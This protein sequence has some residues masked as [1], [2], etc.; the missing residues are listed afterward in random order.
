MAQPEHDRVDRA[1]RANLPVPLTPFIGRVEERATLREA[2]EHNRLVTATGPGGVGKTRLALVVAGDLVGRYADGV[3]FV[4]LVQVTDPHGVAAATAEAV[5]VPE[6]IGVSRRESLLIALTHRE[7][8]LV[9]D[10]CEHLADAMREHIAELLAACPNVRVLATS[11]LR[12]LLPGERVMPVP[13]L[14]LGDDSGHRGDA[15]ELFMVRALASG[16]SDSMLTDESMVQDVCRS[17]AG[18]ALAI[19]LGASRV[20]SMGLD[21]LKRSLASG[22]DLQVFG[23][24]TDTRHRSLRATIE[25]SYHLLTPDEQKVLRACSVFAAP[26]SIDASAAVIGIEVA[27]ALESVGRLVD[28]SLVTL[29][30]GVTTRYRIL[31]AVRQFAHELSAA[32]GELDDL[33]Q[34]HGAWCRSELE[35]LLDTD[36][37]DSSWCDRVDAVVD[38]ARAALTWAAGDTHHHDIAVALAGPL[39]EVVFL[40]GRPSEAQQRYEQAA[41]LADTPAAARDLLLRAARAAL[42]RYV[43][44]EALRL[45]AQ[46]AAVAEA[47]GL[48]ELA[49]LDMA[50]S[51]TMY[52]RHVGTVTIRFSREHNEGLLERAAQL[53]AGSAYVAAAIAVARSTSG[54]GV[55]YDREF[56]ESAV[57]LAAATGDRRL[58]D[59]ARDALCTAEMLADDL[60]AARRTVRERLD[61]MS[62]EPY[63]VMSGMDHT[64]AHLM[65]VHIDLAMGQ[66]GAARRHADDLARLPFLREEQHVALN[67]LMEVG[68]LAGHF[69]EV[70]P[71]AAAF[72]TGW[73]QAG[74]PKVNSHAPAAYA[75]AMVHGILGDAEGRRKWQEI[76]RAI[77]ID[78]ED[79]DVDPRLW[80]EMM[81]AL[82]LLHRGEADAAM[83]LFTVEPDDPRARLSA[84]QAIWRPMYAAAWAEAAHASDAIDLPELLRR[85][86]HVA[87]HN[88]LA[89]GVIRR[90]EA[91]RSGDDDALR[92]LAA[93]FDE[94]D[95]PYQ[96]TRTS[97]M[98][99]APAAPAAAGPGLYGLTDR[100]RE[101][102]ALVAAGKSNPQIAAA[103]YISRKTAEHHVSRILAKLGVTTRA[104]A[105]AV[106]TRH[107]LGQA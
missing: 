29:L 107:G 77:M 71:I 84:N 58:L 97:Q 50:N 16:A 24:G 14:S 3:A 15:V 39:A 1:P 31:E 90:V 42:L 66:L 18:M 63:D 36:A 9:F 56:A 103:L 100:E 8:L 26:F 33:H 48:R 92:R 49:A 11:R 105:A 52:E 37:T 85:A 89:T 64:D 30:P 19:E 23:H 76:K 54:L 99:A 47:A 51:V 61:T 106:A 95:C 91:L 5:G 73:R 13:G 57:A 35:R 55:G 22:L 27:A 93:E 59:A 65:G 67:R 7:V 6:R 102:L 79:A 10:N 32:V 78:P 4:D 72:E 80:P 83:R 53:G 70:L 86:T 28:W 21:G 2:V 75:I 69:D 44:A 20:P 38:D 41:S 43:G 94:M 25:W 96:A 81:D 82:V 88:Q 12:L 101:V 40:R 60:P 68:A 34:R 17:L 104:E 45:Q 98:I 74:C 87:R 62:H 46:A